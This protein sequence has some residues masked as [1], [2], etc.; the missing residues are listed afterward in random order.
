MFSVHWCDENSF[1]IT[2]W[3]IQLIAWNTKWVIANDWFVSFQCNCCQLAVQQCRAFAG[4]NFVYR[5]Q[6]L[7]I[8][9][10]SSVFFHSL[11]QSRNNKDIKSSTQNVIH[12][13]YSRSS[14]EYTR[15]DDENRHS[16]PTHWA[17]YRTIAINKMPTSILNLVTYE[18][19]WILRHSPIPSHL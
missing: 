17:M 13:S 18:W 16:I 10:L 5:T 4:V 6:Y 7:A 8:N 19:A 11:N 15:N 12:F 9:E 3:P 14:S 2:N 1:N